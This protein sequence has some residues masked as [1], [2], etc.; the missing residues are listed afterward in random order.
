MPSHCSALRCS[1]WPAASGSPQHLLQEARSEVPSGESSSSGSI[2]HSAAPLGQQADHITEPG[3]RAAQAHSQIAHE[4][5]E[6]QRAAS[7][8]DQAGSASSERSHSGAAAESGSGNGPVQQ[9]RPLRLARLSV[10]AV[11]G[12]LAALAKGTSLAPYCDVQHRLLSL[13]DHRHSKA[14]ARL[15]GNRLLLSKRLLCA[16][17]LS[18]GFT[19]QLSCNRVEVAQAQNGPAAE[20][21]TELTHIPQENSQ[22]FLS[23]TR[24]PEEQPVRGAPAG[25]PNGAGL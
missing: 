17:R 20:H 9:V 23:A 7:A 10:A 22:H 14:A 5:A 18:R 15:L 2:P 6:E 12:W 1:L 16:L 11:C 24:T 21:G 3:L 25:P 13:M 19:M 4:L 8:S